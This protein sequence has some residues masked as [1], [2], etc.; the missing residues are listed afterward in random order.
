MPFHEIDGDSYLAV[1]KVY[2]NSSDDRGDG[3]NSRFRVPLNTEL[4]NVVSV[5]LTGYA[6]PRSVAPTIPAATSY[7]DFHVIEDGI[8]RYDFSFQIPQT[9]FTVDTLSS[10]LEDTMDELVSDEI[11]ASLY[12]VVTPSDNNVLEFIFGWADD[13]HT[14]TWGLDFKTGPN[15]ATSAYAQLGFEQEDYTSTSRSL[16]QQ[17]INAVVPV[18]LSTFRYVDITLEE[19][20]ELQPIKRVFIGDT[21]DYTLVNQNVAPRTR[22]IT[23]TERSARLRYITINASLA[24]GEELLDIT[25]DLEFTIY[26]LQATENVPQWV[27]ESFLL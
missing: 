23:N 20:P 21:A 10:Y 11:R 18:A 15:S 24:G 8:T 9:S 17:E 1:T 26:N 22:I 16:R 6:I 13:F 7:V 3:T 27:N 5:E 19:I 25:Y 14:Y 12:Y 4:R 2:V